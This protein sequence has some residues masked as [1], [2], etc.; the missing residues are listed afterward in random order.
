MTCLMLIS[1]DFG[2]I[3]MYEG[4]HRKAKGIARVVQ[5]GGGDDGGSG[6]GSLH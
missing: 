2:L 5:T 1:L 6:T 3:L 4:F